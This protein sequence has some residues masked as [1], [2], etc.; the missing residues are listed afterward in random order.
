[1]YD[2]KPLEDEWVRYK[3]K[4]RRPIL[5]GL[6]LLVATAIAIL[7][8]FTNKEYITKINNYFSKKSIIEEV[9]K[10]EKIKREKEPLLVDGALGVLGDKDSNFISN[11][12]TPKTVTKPDTLVD[13]PVL[14]E[15]ANLNIIESTSLSAYK[16]VEKRF[17][18]THNIDD[19][20][21]LATSYYKRGD[22]K[23]AQYWALESNKIDADI[24]E[25]I[26]IFVKSKLK[27]DN[28]NEAISILVSYIKKSDSE[29]A[30]NLLYKIKNNKL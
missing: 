1:M 30:K 8:I 3:E 18:Q 15:K 28:K 17:F 11:N 9:I 12:N 6:A 23:K 2:I 10:V 24:E 14:D 5:I 21:F 7:T 4:Q 13:I 16:D 22:Y 20:L 19:A 26:F 25:S 29:E 27:L